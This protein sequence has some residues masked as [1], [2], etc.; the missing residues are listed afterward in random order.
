MKCTFLPAELERRTKTLQFD[1]CCKAIDQNFE[2]GRDGCSILRF[3]SLV[4]EQVILHTLLTARVW[5]CETRFRGARLFSCESRLALRDYRSVPQ[6]RP[7]T[8]THPFATLAL[9]QAK[10]GGGLVRGMLHFLSRL[11]PS[12]IE[13]CLA[14]LWM[15]ASFLRCHSTTETLNLGGGGGGGGMREGGGGAYLRDYGISTVV[16]CQR[17][18]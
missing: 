5:L 17:S 2:C 14:V 13:K 11:R 1:V 15:L 3:D 4:L 10:G 16:R 7:P 18:E 12:S 8:H 6:I 9:V